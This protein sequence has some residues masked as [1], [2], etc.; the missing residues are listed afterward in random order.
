MQDSFCDSIT[1]FGR[2]F[3]HPQLFNKTFISVSAVFS[4]PQCHFDNANWTQTLLFYLETGMA[5]KTE[6]GPSQIDLTGSQFLIMGILVTG[7]ENP[8]LLD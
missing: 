3:E 2:Q 6:E 4:D 5:E 7:G 1:S 8:T